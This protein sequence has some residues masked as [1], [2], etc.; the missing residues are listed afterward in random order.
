[1]REPRYTIPVLSPLS[2][3]GRVLRRQEWRCLE[4]L[5]LQA[6]FLPAAVL[7][8]ICVASLQPLSQSWRGGVASLE[9]HELERGCSH[10]SGNPGLGYGLRH[11]E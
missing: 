6:P 8:V 2:Q 9:S 5:V 11:N 3:M 4:E 10:K 7:K 1:M